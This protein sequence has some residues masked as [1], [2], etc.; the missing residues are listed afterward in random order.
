[1]SDKVVLKVRNPRADIQQD[2]PHPLPPRLDTLEGKR[3]AV[4]TI[5]PDANIYLDRLA[6]VY[7]VLYLLGTKTFLTVLIP[8][9]RQFFGIMIIIPV[10]LL[11]TKIICITC[12]VMLRLD[13]ILI[14]I[15]LLISDHQIGS[16]ADVV[17]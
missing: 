10:A 11:G 14:K 13:I 7:L 3:I 16:A 8:Y 17:V 15:I 5:K 1:M 4:M 12:K 6:E 2:E 9:I